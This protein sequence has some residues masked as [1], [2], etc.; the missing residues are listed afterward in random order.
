MYQER[1]P[2]LF[3]GHRIDETPFEKGIAGV[4]QRIAKSFRES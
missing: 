1:D 3:V 2:L 4:L